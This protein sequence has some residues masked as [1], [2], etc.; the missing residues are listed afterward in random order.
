ML[1]Y[2]GHITIIIKHHILKHHIPELL[3]IR[4]RRAS[5]G[6]V[7]QLKLCKLH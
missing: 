2:R 3:N 7:K 1:P 6:A 5:S 4:N